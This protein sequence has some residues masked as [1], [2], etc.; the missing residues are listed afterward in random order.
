M[1]RIADNDLKVFD[2]SIFIN[3]GVYMRNVEEVIRSIIVENLPF[4]QEVNI[5]SETNLL[6]DIG[7]DSITLMMMVVS[8]EERFNIELPDEFLTVQSLSN[9]GKLV[10]MVERLI[11]IRKT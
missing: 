3:R 8:I 2:L 9:F 4:Q 5:I 10:N 1:I 11:D 6:E 7:M